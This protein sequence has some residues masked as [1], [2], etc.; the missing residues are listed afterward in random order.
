MIIY[1]GVKVELD[2]ICVMD[3]KNNHIILYF[4]RQINVKIKTVEKDPAQTI[5]HKSKEEL[6][7]HH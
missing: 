5:I 2:A 7:I 6:L 4:I 3:G 1:V